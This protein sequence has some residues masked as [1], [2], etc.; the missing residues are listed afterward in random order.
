MEKQR[1]REYIKEHRVIQFGLGLMAV[2]ATVE[3]ASLPLDNPYMMMGGWA[4]VAGG[5]LIGAWEAVR[6]AD[7]AHPPEE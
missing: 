5:V 1:F 6:T 4:A 7:V 2:G 3:A